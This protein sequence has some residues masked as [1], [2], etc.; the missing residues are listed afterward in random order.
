MKTPYM[1]GVLSLVFMYGCEVGLGTFVENSKRIVLENFV[2]VKKFKVL[3]LSLTDKY[4]KRKK[5]SKTRI[6]IEV[7]HG[8]I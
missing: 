8:K 2:K 4:N 3:K 1:R 6:K 7:K 5:K